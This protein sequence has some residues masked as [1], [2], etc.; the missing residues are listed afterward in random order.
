[1][2]SQ[3]TPSHLTLSDFEGQSQG[4]SNFEALL[5]FVKEQS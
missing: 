3:M 2:E 5:Y 4:D 1:M